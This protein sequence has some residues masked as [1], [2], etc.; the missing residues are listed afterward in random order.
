M[1]KIT[2]SRIAIFN[3]EVTMKKES[4][5]VVSLHP[6][7][8]FWLNAGTAGMGSRFMYLFSNSATCR[9]NFDRLFDCFFVAGMRWWQFLHLQNLHT[10]IADLAETQPRKSRDCFANT[11]KDI[12]NRM[13]R[14][15]A[16]DCLKEVA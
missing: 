15:A 2:P 10:E 4:I 3:S 1:N 6:R 9:L 11:T 7:C 13:K 5:V 14:V 16:A 8:G 12:F